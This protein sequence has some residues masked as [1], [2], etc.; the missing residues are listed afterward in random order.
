[1]FC[2]EGSNLRRTFA[3]TPL[4]HVSSP[5]GLLHTPSFH[6]FVA[7]L[8][9]TNPPG[10][11]HALSLHTPVSRL[12]QSMLL[13]DIPVQSHLAESLPLR[14]RTVGTGSRVGPEE[15]PFWQNTPLRAAELHSR[16]KGRSHSLTSTPDRAALRVYVPV[17][18]SYLFRKP[19]GILY[20]ELPADL[21]EKLVHRIWN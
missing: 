5:A 4:P 14:R 2:L 1:M 20:L 18:K 11:L 7:Y 15:V 13:L 19:L 3:S 10:W 16:T 9:L 21:N 17:K 8:T 12:L 6:A